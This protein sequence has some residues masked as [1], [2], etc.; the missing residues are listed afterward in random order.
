MLDR[1]V[2][3]AHLLHFVFG[4]RK[5]SGNAAGYMRLLVAAGNLWQTGNGIH[6]GRL[7]IAQIQAKL[8]HH[9]TDQTVFLAHQC[10]QQ[11][12]LL[13]LSIAIAL[14]NLLAALQRFHGFLSETVRFHLI[15][16]LYIIKTESVCPLGLFLRCQYIMVKESQ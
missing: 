10:A 4:L 16:L 9:L 13:Y 8:A 6:A 7:R 2:F 5:H 3:I 14:G 15:S 12:N 1:N 11:M